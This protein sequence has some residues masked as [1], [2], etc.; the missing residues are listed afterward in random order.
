MIAAE[1]D[2]NGAS[3]RCGI[4]GRFAN[5]IE[6]ALALG[7]RQVAAIIDGDVGAQFEAGLA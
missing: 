7:Q 6:V 1:K 4:L 5:H 3:N 2:W